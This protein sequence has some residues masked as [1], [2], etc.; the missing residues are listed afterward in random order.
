MS[1]PVAV[2][3]AGGIPVGVQYAKVL[4]REEQ[5]RD[6]QWIAASADRSELLWH[7]AEAPVRSSMPCGLPAEP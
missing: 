7:Q 6:R 1:L 3:A 5:S 4:G 2:V